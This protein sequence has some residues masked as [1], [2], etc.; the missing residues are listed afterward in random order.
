[1]PPTVE[2]MQKVMSDLEKF[3][4]Q[5]EMDVLLKTALVHY[6]FETIHPFLDG[7]GRIGRMLIVLMLLESGVLSQPTL[8]LSLF[9]KTNR[10]RSIK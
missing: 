5:D 10:V 8:Y 3:I 7:N 6:P 2:D 4:H 9:L 1:M